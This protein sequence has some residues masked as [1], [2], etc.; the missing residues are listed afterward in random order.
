MSHELTDEQKE[1][2]LEQ[3]VLRC[4]SYGLGR[5]QTANFLRVSTYRIDAISKALNISWDGQH[6]ATANQARGEQAKQERLKLGDQF[7]KIAGIELQSILNGET[8]PAE[9]KDMITVAGIAVDKDLK[10]ADVTGDP[11]EN[12]EMEAAMQKFDA[13]MYA[14]KANVHGQEPNADDH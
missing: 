1:R 10:L 5:N 9:R 14:V 6:V 3:D 13:F 7:R 11:A 4:R 12:T 8:T 2:K